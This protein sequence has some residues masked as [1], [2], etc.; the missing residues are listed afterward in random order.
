MMCLIST[1]LPVTALEGGE[2]P[3]EG[4]RNITSQEELK[5]ERKRLAHR[6][7]RIIVNSDGNDAVVQCTAATPQALHRCRLIGI[8]GTQV[9]S[10][11]YCTW[12]VG[13]AA[14]TYNTKVG[15][16]FD[17][18]GRPENTPAGHPG[19]TKNMTGDFIKRGTDPLNIV[20]DFCK[21]NDIEVFWSLRMNDTH[22]AWG[23]WYSAVMFPKFKKDHPEWL[24]SELKNP[25]K[26]GSTHG[27]DYNRPKKGGWTALNY[28][29]QEVRD[30]AFGLVEEVCQNYDI[31]GVELDFGRNPICFKRQA[32]GQDARQE[33]RDKMTSLLR[34]I[35]EMRDRVGL[36]RGRPILLSV[37]VPDSVECCE[38]F[39]FDIVRWMEE[40]LIDLC[41]PTAQF[42]L[43]PWEVSIQLGH[44]YGVPVYP[45]LSP[46][47][48]RDPKVKSFRVRTPECIR[49]QAM[50]MWD[51]GAD[52]VYTFNHASYDYHNPPWPKLGDPTMLEGMD[53]VYCSG[54][55]GINR[56]NWW[57]AG[58]ERFLNLPA[59]SPERPR[60]LEPGKPFTYQLC[61]GED[62]QERKTEGVAANVTLRLHV[63][64]L[65]DV[66]DMKVVLNGE[67]LSGGGESGRRP[68]Y[69]PRKNGRWLEYP[70]RPALV[71][72]GNN[73]FEFTL[74]G[75]HAGKCTLQDLL[76]WVR[77]ERG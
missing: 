44:K 67:A 32:W 51:A 69:P 55:R 76:L 11:F 29:H 9:D 37:R 59:L 36:K 1:A 31:D 38:A 35:R 61:V 20:V 72:K 26:R 28:E 66:G 77:Y 62:V 43:N 7:R 23:G 8:K 49:A 75:E 24:V 71:E 65:A 63:R 57:L 17:Y 4:A 25:A 5:R 10:L 27:K 6:R 33:E 68:E 22:D 70:V 19:F 47:H 21:R 18:K 52:G 2:P 46:W 15:E 64:D 73:R 34:R 56:I 53:K 3:E 41:V 45:C 14:Q 50:V 42:R 60:S 13:L 48:A 74:R 12:S 39:G 54:V 30:L 16:V 58:G 40:D